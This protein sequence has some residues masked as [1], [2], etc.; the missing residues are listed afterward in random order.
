MSNAMSPAL[1]AYYA[2][3]ND[4]EAAARRAE[5]V[6]SA[7]REVA[8]R[9]EGLVEQIGLAWSNAKAG[10]AVPFAEAIAS[11]AAAFYVP[12]NIDAEGVHYNDTLFQLRGML[13]NLCQNAKWMIENVDAQIGKAWQDI[14]A[15]EAEC[16]GGEIGLAN[17]NKA[18][19]R[20]ERLERVQMPACKDWFANTTTAYE[21][22]VGE[23]W[24]PFVK[25]DSR[26]KQTADA[27]RA[28]L[29]SMRGR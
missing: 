15:L 2:D 23:K 20:L 13:G 9:A 27:V 29:A 7:E 16:D 14:D 19:D 25:S 22:I 28:R 3:M 1:Q 24:K 12:G 11:L 26:E 17:L 8:A 10:E 21:T 4:R 6:A 18:M 5:A